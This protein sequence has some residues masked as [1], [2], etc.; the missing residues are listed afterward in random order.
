MIHASEGSNDRFH[1]RWHCG[2]Q[3]GELHQA[4]YLWMVAPLDT[5]RLGK[6]VDDKAAYLNKT[7]SEGHGLMDENWLQSLETVV[8]R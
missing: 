6:S 5:R 2:S 8:K 7:Q 4:E 1:A 3:D